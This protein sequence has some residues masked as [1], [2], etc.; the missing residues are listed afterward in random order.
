[1]SEQIP[2]QSTVGRTELQRTP[3]QSA[4]GQPG[5]QMPPQ[6]Q[7]T[8][9]PMGQPAFQQPQLFQS[10]QGA[11]QAQQTIPYAGQVSTPPQ[12]GAV[13]SGQSS[14]AAS[15][16]VFAAGQQAVQS[17]PAQ[18]A[19]AAG[20]EQ[21]FAPEL[22]SLIASL[23]QLANVSEWAESRLVQQGH[24]AAARA[25]EDLH[26]S[27]ETTRDFV[28]RESPFAASTADECGQILQGAIQELQSAPAPEAR[29]V[30]S[31]A[32]QAA[33]QLEASRAYLPQAVGMTR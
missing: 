24:A 10:P 11:P 32:Q 28:L 1:M 19:S 8:Q 30:L 9:V 29:E 20:Y 17:A 2:P 25:C 26:E 23:D 3:Y 31:R 6:Q 4:S 33:Q 7:G 13:Q 14:I 22:Q 15:A 18:M 16:P 12:G 5:S 27:A 21:S